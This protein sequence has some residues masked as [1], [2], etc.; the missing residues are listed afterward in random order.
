MADVRSQIESLLRERFAPQ[1]LVVQDDSGRHVGHAG[2]S[3]GG[4]FSVEL[5]SEAFTGL[6]L[7]DQQR[8]VYEALRTLFPGVIHALALKTSAPNKRG[9]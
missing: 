4:H 9:A 6:S 8:Q 3:G 5:V 7:I 2:A 1:L